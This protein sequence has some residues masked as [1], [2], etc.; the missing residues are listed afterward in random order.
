MQEGEIR[1]D[2]PAGDA[3][4]ADVHPRR[5]AVRS[6]Q[7]FSWSDGDG[8]APSESGAGGDGADGGFGYPH[9]AA[10]GGKD[11]GGGKPERMAIASSIAFSYA[12]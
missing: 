4:P 3:L 10:R 8:G 11:D 9:G 2:P 1:A 5:K 12:V 6:G 7:G